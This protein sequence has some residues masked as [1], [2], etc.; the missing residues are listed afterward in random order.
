MGRVHALPIPLSVAAILCCAS[1][2]HAARFLSVVIER[3]GKVV[4]TLHYQDDGRATPSELCRMLG[5]KPLDFG[6][7]SSL[8]AAEGD[9][10]SARLD[11]STT[12]RIMHTDDVLLRATL[13]NLRLIRPGAGGALWHLPPD[14]VA[15]FAQ[16][17]GV[18]L[19]SQSPISWISLA[20]FL[21]VAIVLA[22]VLT[23]F[24]S[25]VASD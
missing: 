25:P 9:P 1:S 22:L 17:A 7:A 20:V 16:A 2:L 24:R 12:I 3:D 18:T 10:L 15:R 23:R 21:L 19:E 4:Q 11:G 8:A 13:E 6:D 14:E 5:Q